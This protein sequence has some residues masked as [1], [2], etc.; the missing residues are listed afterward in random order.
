M[1][2]QI[3][4]LFHAYS[5]HRDMLFELLSA[6]V[7]PQDFLLSCKNLPIENALQ[8]LKIGKIGEGVI[9]FLFQTNSILLFRPRITVQNFIKI[10]SKLQPQECLQTDIQCDRS[11]FIICPMLC[12]SNGSYKNDAF[13]NIH[14]LLSDSFDFRMMIMTI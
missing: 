11:D 2:D 5:G 4:F 10:K 6:T 14:L 8:G 7:C 3:I 9:R 13:Q 1:G 12:Y